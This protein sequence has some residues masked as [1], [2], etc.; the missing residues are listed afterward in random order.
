MENT[1]LIRFTKGAGVITNSLSMDIVAA[2][3]SEKLA[4]SMASVYDWTIDFS[5]VQKGDS[6]DVYYMQQEVNE[7]PVNMPHVLASNFTHRGVDFKAYRFDQGDGPDWFDPTGASLRKAFLKTPIEFGRM[8]SGFNKAFHPVLKKVKPHLGTDYA[9]PKGTPIR[10]VG[11]GTIIKSEY[12]R[13]NGHYVKIRHNAT[14]LKHST[15]T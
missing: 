6:F 2:G 9:A 3:E 10:A 12:K 13:N 5:H 11:S 14:Y 1:Q 8:S 4:L 7:S 15:C